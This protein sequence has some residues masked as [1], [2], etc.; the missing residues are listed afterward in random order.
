MMPNPETRSGVS[1]AVGAHDLDV[2]GLV[3]RCGDEADLAHMILLEFI[4]TQA[5]TLQSLDATLEAGDP[6]RVEEVLHGIGG[7]AA[8]IGA[9]WIA[10]SSLLLRQ[11]VEHEGLAAVAGELAELRAEWAVLPAIV[12]HAA[13]QLE[14]EL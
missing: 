14:A 13:D 9:T 7:V 3:R 4:R 2:A 8:N 5:P 11:R 6:G 1:T 12:Q 10:T